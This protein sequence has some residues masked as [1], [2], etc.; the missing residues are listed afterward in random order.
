ME[1]KSLFSKQNIV[2]TVK[3]I[4][5]GIISYIVVEWGL[6]GID[7]QNIPLAVLVGIIAAIVFV[8]I[9]VYIGLKIKSKITDGRNEM[10]NLRKEN[11]GLKNRIQGNPIEQ[12]EIE[13]IL[14]KEKEACSALG[15]LIRRQDTAFFLIVEKFPFKSGFWGFTKPDFKDA[16]PG[17]NINRECFERRLNYVEECCNRMMKAPD[18]YLFCM[19]SELYSMVQETIR[20]HNDF[21]IWNEEIVS[22][23]RLADVPYDKQIDELTKRYRITYRETVNKIRNLKNRFDDAVTE[24]KIASPQI[25][26]NVEEREL[27]PIWNKQ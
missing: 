1:S 15:Q 26:W 2:L 27:L 23:L 16:F 6:K 24:K 17:F 13:V 21:G 7:F 8:I 12:S 14:K 11:E 10:S 18:S 9:S 19:I 25:G 5:I 4:V 20:I 22:R 3:A